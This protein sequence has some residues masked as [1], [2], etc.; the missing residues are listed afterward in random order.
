MSAHLGTPKLLGAVLA[1]WL[2]GCQLP[3]LHNPAPL[4]VRNLHPV[5]LTAIHPAPRAAR[6]LPQGEVELGFMADW[7]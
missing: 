1:C 5:Q 3:E 7:A 4:K 6:V 2:L